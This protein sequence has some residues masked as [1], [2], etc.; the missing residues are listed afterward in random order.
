MIDVHTSGQFKQVALSFCLL[1]G[2]LVYER[3]NQVI[4]WIKNDDDRK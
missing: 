4:K 3:E 1:L 2:I